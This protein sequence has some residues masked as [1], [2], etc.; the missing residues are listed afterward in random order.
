MP[1]EANTF[2]RI[3]IWLLRKQKITTILKASLYSVSEKQNGS[4]YLKR[5]SDT[6]HQTLFCAVIKTLIDIQEEKNILSFMSKKASED[7]CCTF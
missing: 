1:G 2:L 5:T 4:A 3:R 7:F 6:L